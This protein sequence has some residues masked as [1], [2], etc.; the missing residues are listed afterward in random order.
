M[1]IPMITYD[2]KVLMIRNRPRCN[3]TP[4]VISKSFRVETVKG[5]W[6]SPETMPYAP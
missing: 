6:S 4:C 1:N 3:T 5:I 2:R